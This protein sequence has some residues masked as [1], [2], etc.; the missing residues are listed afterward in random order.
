MLEAWAVDG[1]TLK[2]FAKNSRG[3]V[4]DDGLIA[5]LRRVQGL[6]RGLWVRQQMFYAAVSLGYHELA[7]GDP[8]LGDTDSLMRT[9]QAKY[10]PFAYVPGTHFQLSFGHLEGY[11]AIYY[12][13][14]WSLV[15]AKDLLQPFRAAPTLSDPQVAQRYRRAV[16]DPGG[17][18]DAAA[19]V[20]D[21]LGRDTSFDAFG[22]WVNAG[23]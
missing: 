16:L 21:F 17:A 4:I 20:A 9:L 15:L 2:R 12:T 13:Y 8:A 1:P 14:M 22:A 11:S 3:E 19:L 7:P 5:A 23:H 18:K 6:G 10:G